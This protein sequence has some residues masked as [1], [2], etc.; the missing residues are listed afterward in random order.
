MRPLPDPMPEVD[1]RFVIRVPPQP[2]LRFDRNDYSL[3]PHLIWRWVTPWSVALI[4]CPAGRVQAGA[5][6]R[7][8][9]VEVVC[10]QPRR[11]STSAA[12][13]H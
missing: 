12:S 11:A 7:G 9:G 6:G 3:D 10:A 1:R 2:Y 13:G 5:L 4:Q 8:T